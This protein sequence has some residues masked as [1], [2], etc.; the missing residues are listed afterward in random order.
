MAKRAICGIVFERVTISTVPNGQR[1]YVTHWK[2]RD[3]VTPIPPPPPGM[4]SEIGDMAMRVAFRALRE[5][6]RV[7]KR[8]WMS[9]PASKNY[10]KITWKRCRD[11]LNLEQWTR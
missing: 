7:E 3:W 1:Y 6:R 2:F 8:E 5:G 10:L 9:I 4:Q 11:W